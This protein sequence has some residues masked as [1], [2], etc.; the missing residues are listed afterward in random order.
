MYRAQPRAP[1]KAM[2]VA[3][4]KVDERHPVIQHTPQVPVVSRSSFERGTTAPGVRQTMP[5]TSRSA[6]RTVERP[7]GSPPATRSYEPAQ[8]STPPPARSSPPARTYSPS[9]QAAPSG[10]TATQPSRDYKQPERVAPTYRSEPSPRV[11]APARGRASETPP[12]LG[13]N[14]HVYYPKTYHQSEETRQMP[15]SAPRGQPAPPPQ[16]GQ[17]GR[18][19]RKDF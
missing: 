4:Q 8:R 12:G 18:S 2:P 1:A 7:G 6:P 5:Q 10:P 16:S 11:E 13:N 19:G 3:V 9:A 14:P 17:S 15:P